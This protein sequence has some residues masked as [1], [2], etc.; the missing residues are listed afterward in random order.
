MFLTDSCG[1]LASLGYFAERRKSKI[2]LI[3][4]VDEETDPEYIDL[5]ISLKKFIGGSPIIEKDRIDSRIARSVEQ[6]RRQVHQGS[7]DVHRGPIKA[8]GRALIGPEIR[9]LAAPAT[10]GRDPIPRR[11]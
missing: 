11:S 7:P 8:T 10:A 2:V 5:P 4:D 3:F 6:L 9:G 1:P